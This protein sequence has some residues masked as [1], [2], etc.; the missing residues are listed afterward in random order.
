MNTLEISFKNCP[1]ELHREDGMYVIKGGKHGNHSFMAGDNDRMK[2]HF[3]GYL[4]NNGFYVLA[5]MVR[6]SQI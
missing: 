1:I 4:E 2:A 5:Q 3:S 6:E